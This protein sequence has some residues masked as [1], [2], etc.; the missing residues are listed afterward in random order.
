[1]I[2]TIDFFDEKTGTWQAVDAVYRIKLPHRFEGKLTS[3]ELTIRG[4]TRKRASRLS[5][6][7]LATLPIARIHFIFTQIRHKSGSR[8]KLNRTACG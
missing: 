7:L 5:E 2:T 4:A 1:M 3:G 6:L 8:V